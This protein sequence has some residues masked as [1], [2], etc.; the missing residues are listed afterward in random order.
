[1]AD[2]CSLLVASLSEPRLLQATI[3][4]GRSSGTAAEEEDED[5][6]EDEEKREW[7]TNGVQ[8]PSGGDHT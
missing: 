6:D 3:R 7:M 1:M 5:E 4:D 2:G 8:E